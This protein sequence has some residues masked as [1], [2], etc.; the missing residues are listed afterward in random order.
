MAELWRIALVLLGTFIGAFGALF[1][2]KGSQTLT[3]NFKKIKFNL[4]FILKILQLFLGLFLYGLATVP[5]II[6]IKGAELSILYPIV[7]A[8]YIWVALLSIIFLKEK[9]N[10]FKWAGIFII[11]IGIVIITLS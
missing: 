10:R 7:S 2:K 9:M 5:F 3:L 11:I 1:L 6:A 4:K 8:S